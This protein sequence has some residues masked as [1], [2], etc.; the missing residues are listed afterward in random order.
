MGH[1]ALL[2]S[3]RYGERTAAEF[4]E[5]CLPLAPYVAEA[6]GLLWKLWL[7]DEAEGL[8]SGVYLFEDEAAAREYLAGPIMAMVRDDTSNTEIQTRLLD[9]MEEH[10]AITR[11]PIAAPEGGAGAGRPS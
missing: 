2:L 7:L 8:F 5:Q 4:R 10:S 3:H 9:V 1:K 11:G 6:P